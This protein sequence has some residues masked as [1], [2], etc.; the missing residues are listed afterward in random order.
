MKTPEEIKKG[1]ECCSSLDSDMCLQCP[2][3]D[4]YIACCLDKN[5]DALA[6]IIQL[7]STISQVNKALCGKENATLDEVLRGV[8]Q[9]KTTLELARS[10]RDAINKDRIDLMTRLSQA[11]RE[12]DAAAADLKLVG[13]CGTCINNEGGCTTECYIVSGTLTG[14]QWR[15]VCEENSQ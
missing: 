14:W 8:S 15:G 12:R 6:Y 7:E 11:E 2:Y 3:D 10:E 13:C 9:L 5:Q 4:G 1:L